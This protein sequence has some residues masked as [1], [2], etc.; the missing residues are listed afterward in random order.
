MKNISLKSIKK[1]V[2]DKI[3]GLVDNYLANKNLQNY[4]LLR[5]T[6]FSGIYD[7]LL[8][9][10]IEI[11]DFNSTENYI[12]LKKDN[13]LFVT[14]P[15]YPYIVREIFCNHNYF[16]NPQYLKH[17]DYSIFDIGMNRGY[18]TPYFANQ[19][20]CKEVYGFEIEKDVFEIAKKNISLNIDLK[21]K[22]SIFDFG[23]GKEDGFFKTYYLPNRDGINTVSKEFL[24]NYAPE[25]SEHIIE[26]EN[27]IKKTSA[28]F[29]DLVE[30]NSVNHIILKIDVEGAEYE[31]FDDLV[32]DY[33]QFFNN[34]DL[35]IGEAHLG[36]EPIVSKLTPLGFIEISNKSSN[37]GKTVDFLF[38]KK[39]LI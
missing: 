33:P 18:A 31:I 12:Y 8:A 3:G 36:L 16:I 22:I 6:A 35:I 24:I 4:P 5:K 26:K 1:I 29:K 10:N 14:T 27:I 37:D 28:I 23:L 9:H 19:T 39:S 32:T 21:D 7:T 25:E 30:K 17:K 11:L 2:S 34:V 13:I 15:N 38:V 20:W